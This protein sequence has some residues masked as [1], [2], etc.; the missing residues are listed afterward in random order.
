MATFLFAPS[1]LIASSI[2]VTS[3]STSD[4]VSQPTQS[5]S[6]QSP[7]LSSASVV[8]TTAA[9]SMN[10]ASLMT[11]TMAISSASA[12]SSS[13]TTSASAS[14][15]PILSVSR[16]SPQFYVGL[17]FIGVVILACLV[18][19]ASWMLRS[20]RRRP[21]RRGESNGNSDLENQEFGFGLGLYL[22]K[23]S[24][25][26]DHLVKVPL[27]DFPEDDRSIRLRQVPIIPQVSGYTGSPGRVHFP[28]VHPCALQ[29]GSTD[30]LQIRNQ[31]LGPLHVKNYVPGDFSSSCDELVKPTASPLH[32]ILS[33][34][35]GTPHEGKASPSPRFR[36]VGGCASSVR[37]PPP[38]IDNGQ[39][40][41]PSIMNTA[42][43]SSKAGEEMFSP[44]PMPPFRVSAP[45]TTNGVKRADSWGNT[46]R[47][48]IFN[49]LSGLTGG[50]TKTVEEE[51]YTAPIM[52]S[53]RPGRWQDA[54]FPRVDSPA[55][56]SI[57][58]LSSN[59][60]EETNMRPKAID[61]GRSIGKV[62]GNSNPG[63]CT[64]VPALG[65]CKDGT[66]DARSPK[67]TLPLKLQKK[68]R[69]EYSENSL[70]RASSVYS[71]PGPDVLVP[72]RTRVSETN[73]KHRCSLVQP[74][75]PR[76][77]FLR[78]ATGSSATSFSSDCSSTS[79]ELAEGELAAKR[80]MRVRARRKQL[81]SST[82]GTGKRRLVR[83][84]PRILASVEG[85]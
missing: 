47:T 43:N 85:A 22:E 76:P 65:P 44:L 16:H 29:D 61:T 12:T 68:R 69:D 33:A 50:S 19:F 7:T 30:T 20:R 42:H 49:A 39:A 46:L 32:N 27:G 14:T 34:R 21:S 83:N 24:E 52:D 78:R 64:D 63:L 31:T 72:A 4:G 25:S 17:S 38:P 66:T 26:N 79:R 11:T 48:S 80:V 2:I 84:T 54:L 10:L 28:P 35:Y 37:L 81:M 45:E 9:S 73:V 13:S 58:P 71:Q 3:A 59:R 23:P 18:S 57:L 74:T 15:L 51:R 75:P 62:A 67:P 36:G 6:L 60:F 70:S 41:V 77:A 56:E 40:P 53:S 55:V 5:S 8:S 1:T 82:M